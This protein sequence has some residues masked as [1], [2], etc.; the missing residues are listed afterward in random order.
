MTYPAPRKKW[1]VEWP[2][3]NIAYYR[4]TYEAVR[5]ITE[6]VGLKATVYHWADGHWQLFEHCEPARERQR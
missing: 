6:H 4:S 2:G 3:E 1:R 5:S